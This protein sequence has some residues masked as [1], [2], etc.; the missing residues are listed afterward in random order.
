MLSSSRLSDT[1]RRPTFGSLQVGAWGAAWHGEPAGLHPLAIRSAA[2]IRVRHPARRSALGVNSRTTSES[3][4]ARVP[5]RLIR[6]ARSLLVLVFS[7]RS[8]N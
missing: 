6:K 1:Q 4:A 8:M 3:Q 2:S 5:S 7:F